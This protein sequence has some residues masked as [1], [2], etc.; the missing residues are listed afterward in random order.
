MALPVEKSAVLPGSLD[1]MMGD[2]Q[3]AA[4]AGRGKQVPDP[5]SG[6]GGALT[7][8]GGITRP[9]ML[10]EPPLGVEHQ[11]LEAAAYLDQ[12]RTRAAVDSA[13]R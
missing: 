7:A 5:G 3:R 9:R 13:G 12:R 10:V 11:H 8:A 6:A 1:G 2:D 4:P